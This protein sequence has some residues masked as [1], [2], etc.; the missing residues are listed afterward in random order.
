MKKEHEKVHVELYK[1]DARLLLSY[2]TYMAQQKKI[3]LE[4]RTHQVYM[5]VGR[6][7]L[8]ALEEEE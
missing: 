5:R 4:N 8:N 7:I 2:F 3:D 1:D 6:A